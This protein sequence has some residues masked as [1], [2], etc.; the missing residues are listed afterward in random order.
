MLEIDLSYDVENNKEYL[1]ED[2]ILEV[3][4]KG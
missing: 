2:K 3:Y 4:S 1:D